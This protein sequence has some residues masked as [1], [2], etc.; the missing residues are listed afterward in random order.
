MHCHGSR[1]QSSSLLRL[2]YI[3]STQIPVFYKEKKIRPC[4]NVFKNL[5]V[6]GDFAQATLAPP[7]AITPK[8]VITA[9]FAQR[10]GGTGGQALCPLLQPSV[11]FISYDDKRNSTELII[12]D[13]SEHAVV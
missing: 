2:Q 6:H 5:N 3:L 4:R 9:L 10:R 7:D 13:F 1:K 11:L 12:H 8:K